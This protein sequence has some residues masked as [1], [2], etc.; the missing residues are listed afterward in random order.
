MTSKVPPLSTDDLYRR[1]IER[2]G[3]SYSTRTVIRDYIGQRVELR[4]CTNCQVPEKPRI[5]APSVGI[6]LGGWK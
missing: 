3:H 6:N 5:H 2:G 4:V 1:C